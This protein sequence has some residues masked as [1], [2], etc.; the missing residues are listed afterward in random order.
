M[1]IA[2]ITNINII[3]K[4]QHGITEEHLVVFSKSNPKIKLTSATK[5]AFLKMAEAATNDGLQLEIASGFRDFLRQRTIFSEK[6][7]GIRKVLDKN[8]QPL[9][10]EDLSYDEKINAIL[11]FSAIPGMSRH[12]FGTDLDVFTPNTIPDNESLELTNIEYTTGHQQ[13]ISQWLSENMHKYGFFR[14]YSVHNPNFAD[15]LWHISYWP[16][17]DILTKHLNKEECLQFVLEKA[18]PGAVELQN[19]INTQFDA[20]FM[21][22]SNTITK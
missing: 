21:L 8:E 14:P 20:R 19:I 4:I 11:Y 17:A 16:E 2:D 3:N 18:L 10:I 5:E 22:L 1:N 6:F 9:K 7:S 12:H 13:R 15:E